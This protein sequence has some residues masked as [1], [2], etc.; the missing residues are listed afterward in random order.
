MQQQM[1][2]QQG[3]AAESA[4]KFDPEAA[5]LQSELDTQKIQA[6]IAAKTESDLIKMRERSRLTQ[7]NDAAKGIVDV[8]KEKLKQQMNPQ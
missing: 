3:L 6:Q 1:A 8:S 7:E 4:R 2:Q 5:Q